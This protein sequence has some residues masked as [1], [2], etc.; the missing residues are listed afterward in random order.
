MA[1][2]LVRLVAICAVSCAVNAATSPQVSTKS[3]NVSGT[4]LKSFLGK[5]FYSFKGMDE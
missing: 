5:S 2:Q 3:G 4:V 1:W